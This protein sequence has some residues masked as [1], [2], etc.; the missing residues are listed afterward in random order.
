MKKNNNYSNGE[1]KTIPSIITE[2]KKCDS[3]SRSSKFYD[4]VIKSKKIREIMKTM[5]LLKISG[6]SEFKIFTKNKKKKEEIPFS[7]KKIED[8]LI[9]EDQLEKEKEIIKKEKFKNTIIK[10]LHKM[11]ELNIEHYK[12]NHQ[13]LPPSIG[14]YN[15]NYDSIYK[16]TKGA[17][18]M[19]SHKE[20]KEN[21]IKNRSGNNII[22]NLSLN[23][24]NNKKLYSTISSRH[25]YTEEKEKEKEKDRDKNRNIFS[26][27]TNYK[28]KYPPIFRNK[29]NYTNYNAKTI[30][31]FSSNRKNHFKSR[32]KKILLKNDNKNNSIS[33]INNKSNSSIKKI[34]ENK[35][36]IFN[37]TRTYTLENNIENIKNKKDNLLKNKNQNNNKNLSYK[38]IFIKPSMPSIGYYN[39]KYDII[40]T[41]IPKI[42]FLY[43]NN[44]NKKDDISYK[45]NLLRKVITKYNTDRDYEVIKVL[46]DK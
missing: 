3:Y 15:P 7:T 22:K 14:T 26:Y 34:G 40:N 30:N 17:I 27:N 31:S 46:N 36:D 18:I 20:K 41:N 37:K 5:G 16:K 44:K 6:Y 28:N 23:N 19:E 11:T 42:S 4:K 45:K 24:T 2:L 10:K 29:N 25:L 1:K 35:I 39:P 8:F 33:S 12:M 43:H 21:I 9:R 38:S 32:I 13:F